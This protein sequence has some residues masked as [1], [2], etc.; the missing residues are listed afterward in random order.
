MEM[1]REFTKKE[2]QQTPDFQNIQLPSKKQSYY[3]MDFQ[4]PKKL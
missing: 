3:E 4:P 1:I 2:I